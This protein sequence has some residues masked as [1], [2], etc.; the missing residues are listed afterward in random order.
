MTKLE[1][2]AVHAQ[3]ILNEKNKRKTEK[4]ATDLNAATL[5]IFQGQDIG[6]GC[7][8]GRGHGRGRERGRGRHG[9]GQGDK[10]LP[11]RE[12]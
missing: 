10:L 5:T 3:K 7:G 8:R 6:Q 12:H 4:R 1:Q 2:Y 11:V 9:F